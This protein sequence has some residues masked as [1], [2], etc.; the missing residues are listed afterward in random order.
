MSKK[1]NFSKQ[2]EIKIINHKGHESK[3]MTIEAAIEYLKK[4]CDS[5]GKWA[6][7]DGVP[8]LDTKTFNAAMLENAED[9]TLTNQLAGGV[10]A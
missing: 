8:A 9:I 3:T 10:T 4:A 7:I 1:V 6:F 2:V 5:Q